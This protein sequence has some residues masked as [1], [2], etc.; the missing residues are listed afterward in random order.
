MSGKPVDIGPSAPEGGPTQGRK[1]ERSTIRFPYGDLGD[2]QEIAS[3]IHENAGNEC[4]LDQLA[5][6]MGQTATSGS[7][8]TKLATAKTFGVISTDRG[9]QVSLTDL[10]RR[11]ADPA[12]REAAG[13]EAFLAVPLYER[14]YAEFKGRS[15]PQAAGVERFMATEGVSQKQVSRARQAFER[16]ALQAGF[17]AHGKDRLVAPVTREGS[18]PG[19]EDAPPPPNGG[20]G[21]GGEDEPPGTTTHTLKV[22][23]S[24]AV[25]QLRVPHDLTQNQ[26]VQ[27]FKQLK[28]LGEFLLAQALVDDNSETPASAL[29]DIVPGKDG[30]AG[31]A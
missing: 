28:P 17:F 25:A 18:S 16:S 19:T 13:A 29:P 27:V 6:F 30:A 5:A 15:L 20:R 14:V 4:D 23:G 10:G 9:G 12:G 22:P 11:L 2:A 21:G 24:D 26:V 3:K 1:N 7:F 31:T 8:R